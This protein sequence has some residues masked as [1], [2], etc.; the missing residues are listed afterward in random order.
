MG[1]SIGEGAMADDHDDPREAAMAAAPAL[2]PDF[3]SSRVTRGQIDKLKE[4]HQRRLKMKQLVSSKSQKNSKGVKEAS[5]KKIDA[6][7]Q[8]PVAHASMQPTCI[9]DKNEDSPSYPWRKRQKLH[10]GLDTK[11]RWERK[12]NM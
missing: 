2:H 12:A 8:Q 4:L 6:D 9:T 10:W 1:K 11:E 3:L 5:T 7:L